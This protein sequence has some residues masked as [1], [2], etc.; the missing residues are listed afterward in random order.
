MIN[1]T[2]YTAQQYP[3]LSPDNKET[4]INYCIN[5]CK[6]YKISMINDQLIYQIPVSQFQ[7][8]KRAERLLLPKPDQF[9]INDNNWH[10]YLLK[11]NNK[12]YK[13]TIK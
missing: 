10:D 13:I 12:N 4:I 8:Y 3:E 7:A 6:N 2:T 11:I 1:I 9:I 5:Y